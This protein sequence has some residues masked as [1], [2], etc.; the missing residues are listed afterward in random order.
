MINNRVWMGGGML[1]WVVTALVVAI[2]P[3]AMMNKGSNR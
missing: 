2:L 1:I 3:V